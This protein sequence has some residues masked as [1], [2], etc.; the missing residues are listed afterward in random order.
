MSDPKSSSG[1]NIVY[2]DHSTSAIGASLSQSSAAPTSLANILRDALIEVQT[3][4]TLRVAGLHQ[5][6]IWTSDDFDEPLP[7][8]FW[9]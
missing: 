2:I 6:A 1:Q 7:D 9:T 8:E 3:F 5:G 4:I